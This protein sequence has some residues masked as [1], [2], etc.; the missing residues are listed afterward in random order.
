[1][2][3]WKNDFNNIFLLYVDKYKY[4]NFFKNKFKKMTYNLIIKNII[5]NPKL[6]IIKEYINIYINRICKH[7]YY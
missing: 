1:M 6:F 7:L 4:K 2:R 3:I 5:I